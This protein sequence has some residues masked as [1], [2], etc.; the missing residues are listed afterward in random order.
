M[1]EI[2]GVV[3]AIALGD[4][5]AQGRATAGAGDHPAHG[6][7]IAYILALG[8]LGGC[9]TAFLNLFKG[10]DAD[11]WLMLA[12]QPINP[13]VFRDNV[14]GINRAS[15]NFRDALLGNLAL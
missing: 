12:F 5:R 2:I 8:G 10:G 6:E 3:A 7:R 9:L 4:G 13:I 14:A 15:K 11:N 1:A